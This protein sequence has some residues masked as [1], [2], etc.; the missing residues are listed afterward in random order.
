VLTHRSDKGG[1]FTLMLQPPERIGADDV[2]PKELV[3]VLDTSGSMSGFPIEKAKETMRLAL[4]NLYPDDTFNLI[5]F[6][7]DTRIL[8][9]Q[10]V[11][12][13]KANLRR[14][15]QFL[16]ASSGYGGTEMMSAIKAALEPSD[17]QSHVRIVCFMTDGFVG[18]D[19][20][21][22]AEIQKHKNARVFAFGIGSSV[23]R[24]LL[25]NM[26]TAGGGDVEYVG[27][28][29]DGSAA[30]KRF[31]QRVR[32]PLLTDISIDW[33]EL[34][35]T[36]VYPKRIPDLF[37]AKPVFVTG[38]YSAPGSGTIKLKGN[39]A[40]SP[41]TRE[42]QV[43]LPETMALHDVLAPLWARARIDS[44]MSEDYMG[45]FNGKMQD[46]LRNTITQLGIEFRLM[47]QFT[48]FVA[49]EE[50]SVSDGGTLRRIDVPVDVPE[51]MN[52]DS[53]GAYKV[54]GPTG[55]FT[56]HGKGGAMAQGSYTFSIVSPTPLPP[57][58]ARRSVRTAG[59]GAGA[60]G[61]VGGGG[62]GAGAVYPTPPNAPPTV[63]VTA[64][65]EAGA[66]ALQP[67]ARAV[68]QQRAE[69]QRAKLQPL[70][71]MIVVR[72]T[73]KQQADLITWGGFVRDRKA[74]VQLWLTDK[75]E[76]TRAKLKELGFEIVLDHASSNLMIGRIPVDKLALLP[77][78][79]FVRYV[80]P[81]ISK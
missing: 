47:T 16:A 18:N 62:G 78:L 15:Q 42:I 11:R 20:Q 46:D 53:I 10:P 43:A 17:N 25:D 32:N 68:E 49:V 76:L 54:G 36:D 39:M 19:M 73:P 8:F 51:G 34:Q 75:S 7:G 6:S 44:L 67:D 63:S 33:G 41:F 65:V 79:E 27:L 37:G 57:A 3:F 81:Q 66:S 30:A 74:E 64:S 4:D 80:S 13:T 24:F 1:F 22:I 59:V 52:R 69:R 55:L 61:G 21:I 70:I 28:N 26:A 23:N 60:G 50:I 38:R 14:A 35:V 45:V 9:E 29:D 12:A 77:D 5:T 72:L 56:V 40:G 2:T 58:A 31:H 71:L 48:S